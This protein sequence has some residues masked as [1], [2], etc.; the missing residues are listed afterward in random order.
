LVVT[1]LPSGEDA[2]PVQ[3]TRASVS[4]KVERGTRKVRHTLALLA[5]AQHHQAGSSPCLLH[6]KQ[7][8]AA[9]AGRGPTP[10][11]L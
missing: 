2:S 5:T 10:T 8:F 3:P 1:A 6:G 4:T 9:T 11:R 7:V